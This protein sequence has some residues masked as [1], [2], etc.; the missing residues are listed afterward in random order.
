MLARVCGQPD[1][2][3][4]AKQRIASVHHQLFRNAGASPHPGPA[5]R[6]DT[7]DDDIAYWLETCKDNAALGGQVVSIR[8]NPDAVQTLM[9]QFTDYVYQQCRVET[10][11]TVCW[12]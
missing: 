1:L 6:Q 9:M 8:A 5:H 4:F 11:P 2:F 7:T 3:A 10:L 12:Q